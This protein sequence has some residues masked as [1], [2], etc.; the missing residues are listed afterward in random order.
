VA[1]DDF[2]RVPAGSASSDAVHHWAEQIFEPNEFRAGPQF[3]EA[4]RTWYRENETLLKSG[5]FQAVRP[6]CSAIRT[7]RQQRPFDAGA[8]PSE[9][10]QRA[11]F[12]KDRGLI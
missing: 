7:V 5:D 8:R 9:T 11:S 1:F 4:G 12:R 3:L 2:E 10:K 6:A